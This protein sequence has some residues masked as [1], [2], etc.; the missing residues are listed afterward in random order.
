MQ[1]DNVYIRSVPTKIRR[2]LD[3][4]A[5][6]DDEFEQLDTEEFGGRLFKSLLDMDRDGAV[7][8]ADYVRRKMST[9]MNTPR[10]S[11]GSS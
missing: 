8:F 5:L 2:T 4:V 9:P 6:P 11:S 10:N 3:V 7:M 1:A